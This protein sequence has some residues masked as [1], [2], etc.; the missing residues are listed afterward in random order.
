MTTLA[1]ALPLIHGGT[2]DQRISEGSSSQVHD[3]I[4]I[5]LRTESAQI[6][7]VLAKPVSL[8]ERFRSLAERWRRETGMLS[9]TTR[10]VTNPAYRQIIE[11]GPKV[12]PLILGELRQ[13]PDHWFWA[14]TLLSGE[15]PV[16]R[17]NWGDV[18]CMAAAWL[19]WGRENCFIN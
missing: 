7:P 3:S 6:A 2:A 18:R 4:L 17:E 10:I 14:L 5:S 12:I 16:P 13:R 8:E 19:A 11:L 15:D 9:S 1:G